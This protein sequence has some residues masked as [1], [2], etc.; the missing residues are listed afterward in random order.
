[1]LKVVAVD[2]AL[3]AEAVAAVKLFHNLIMENHNS[4]NVQTKKRITIDIDQV[5]DSKSEN[6]IDKALSYQDARRSYSNMSGNYTPIN[7]T[8][9]Q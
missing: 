8:Y 7:Q 6:L 9:A 2:P 1:M 5:D 4:V 3:V